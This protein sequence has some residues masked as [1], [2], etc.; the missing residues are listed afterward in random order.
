MALYAAYLA[1]RLHPNIEQHKQLFK[2]FAAL[3]IA[4]L[5]GLDQLN[6]PS[7]SMQDI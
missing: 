4:Y 7:T 5:Q 2:E 3:L 6:L 1:K